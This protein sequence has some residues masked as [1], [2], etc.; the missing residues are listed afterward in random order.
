[1]FRSI[2]CDRF[3]GPARGSARA[4]STPGSRRP[5]RRARHRRSNA[6][7]PPP[8]PNGKRPSSS[9]A[10]I[11]AAQIARTIREI[12]PTRVF[13]NLYALGRTSTVVWAV[14]TPDGILLIDAGYPDQLES[15]L[16]PGLRAAG[17]DPNDVKYVL[18]A[19]G[20]ADHFGGAVVLPAARRARRVVRRG[21]EPRSRIRPRHRRAR[22]PPRPRRTGLPPPRRDVVVTRGRADRVRRPRDHAGADSGPHAGIA[23][24]RVRACRT[25]RAAHT[26]ALFGGSIL[27]VGPH[28]RTMAFAQYVQSLEHFA[29]VTRRLGVDVEIQNHPLYDGFDDEARA[30]REARSAATR[31]RSSSAR[32]AINA[33]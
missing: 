25:E 20:H 15:V 32:T 4:R 18:V 1:M 10:A 11:R 24:L 27:L 3:R 33:S 19:H 9:S 2:V 13:D 8:A 22:R 21:L 16:L 17:L 14:T 31:I 28:L 30:A 7:A 23:R 26:A 6:H 29:A 12:A 5:I